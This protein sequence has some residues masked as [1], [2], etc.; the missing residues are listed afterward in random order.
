[1]SDVIADNVNGS[2]GAA[3]QGVLN[4]AFGALWPH[5]TDDD[6]AATDFLFDP[7]S[8]F[9]RIPVRLV[10]FKREIGFLDPCRVFVDAQNRV[11]V[12]DLLH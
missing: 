1:M 9:Q 10:Y 6:L 2:I 8:L 12:R 4:H 11:F 5:R 7:Q 3:R